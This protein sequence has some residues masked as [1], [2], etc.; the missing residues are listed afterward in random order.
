VESVER[1]D[2]KFVLMNIYEL[3]GL[4]NHAMVLVSTT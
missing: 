4:V 1:M 3:I 2:F